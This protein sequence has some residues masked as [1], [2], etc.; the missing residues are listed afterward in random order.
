MSGFVTP[1]PILFNYQSL[2]MKIWKTVRSIRYW[3]AF[4]VLLADIILYTRTNAATIAPIVLIVGFIL[5][6][7]TAYVFVY[8]LCSIARLYG[9][10]VRH[11]RRIATFL[12]IVF[13]LIVALQSIG[14]LSARD[15]FVLV[16]LVMIGYAYATYAT[17]RKHNLEG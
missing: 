7:L 16:P 9:L 17:S 1:A 8:G 2:I 6:A 12:S 5:L 10:P 15:I 4:A 14:E 13:G 3:Q 11:K